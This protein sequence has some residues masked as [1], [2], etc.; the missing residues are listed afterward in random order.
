MT[1]K[2]QITEADSKIKI[3]KKGKD[4]IEKISKV[5][6]KPTVMKKT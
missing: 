5:G 1:Y 2:K 6:F 4:R 3:V